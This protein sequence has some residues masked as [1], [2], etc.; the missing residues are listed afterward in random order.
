MKITVI[1]GGPGGLYA[2]LLT[3]KARPDWTVEVFE[4][5]QADD[6]FGFGVVFSDETLD[7]F[8]NRDKP[9]FERIRDHF[10]YWD[11]VAVNFKGQVMRC[12]GN[13]FCGTSRQ[14]LLTILQERCAE[15]GVDMHFGAEIAPETLHERF[16]DS[17]VIVACDGVNSAIRGHFAD[18]F[19]PTTTWRKNRF[20]WM[21]ST[22][23]MGE[24]NYF[25]RDTAH[26]PVVAHS[27]QYEA[28]R[29][30]WIF[31]MDEATW[32]GHQFDQDD[33]TAS[34]AKLEAIFAEELQGHPLLLNRSNWRNFP[35]VSC[36]GW[37]SG[38]IVLLGDAKASA[39]FS[40]GSGTKLAME[41]AIALSDALV[42][43]AEQDVG[44]AFQ[45][46]ETAR[47][48]PCEIIQHNADVSLSWF[49]HMGRS[50]DMDP[51]QFA[52][53]VM[54]RAKAITYDNLIVRDPAFIRRADDE[55]YQRHLSVTGQ[56]LCAARPTPMFTG[57][58]LRQ[59]Q[60]QNRVAVAPMALRA[61][62]RDGVVSDLGRVHYGSHA[63]G[64]A[65]LIITETLAVSDRA[66]I[67][68]KS[69]G[70]W[71]DEQAARWAEVVGFVHGNSGAKIAA[72]IGHAGRK[73]AI[74]ARAL[75]SASPLPWQAGGPVPAALDRDGMARIKADFVA[76]AKR[77]RDAGFDMITLHAAHGQL[78][79]SFLSPLSNV[80]EDAF[81]GA[82]DN[83]LTF[84][85]DV[86]RAM[87]AQWPADR[88]MA[89]QI[90]GSD[91]AEGGLSEADLF[92]IARA[93]QDA[94]ADLID[95]SAGGSVAAETPPQGR[96]YQVHLA[97][98]VRNV[99]GLATM[100]SGG[101]TD[102]A[103][104]NTILHTR[105]ADLVALDH[106]QIWNPHFTLHAAAW[107]GATTGAVVP[108]HI[109]PAAPEA[110]R[111]ARRARAK[112]TNLQRM[113]APGRHT[114]RRD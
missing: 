59:M 45:A 6:T 1:G 30:T 89:V 75:V 14:T 24:F 52:M 46:Y 29:S 63:L 39:H 34:G 98:A 18:Q 35:R 49:E 11:D 99:V 16:A 71:T 57:L 88:P 48:A 97:E 64:G 105:R 101:I 55:F 8:L 83:R 47:R 5:N 65:G 4:R 42:A 93:F 84:P 114:D 17:D 110:M 67:C 44:A 54:C 41:C 91:W 103:Q 108:A 58:R 111:A 22:R 85:I 90:S 113:A 70:L 32:Q 102:A 50:W 109:Q 80:R 53:V 69:A 28:A 107:Y 27:Y 38:K 12:G 76:A 95:V 13:G 31:E 81:G 2:A 72:Q 94:G 10:A 37:S 19:K 78:L 3:K 56:D 100:T 87:R 68:D 21:G 60:V 73:S 62:D 36:A 7:E 104:I 33:E 15:L 20:C 9:V 96:M 26:G 82:I 66:R 51:Y 112:L 92:D 86:F 106:A 77:A 23:Q 25:F 43:H 40:I 79:G 61:C 74:D